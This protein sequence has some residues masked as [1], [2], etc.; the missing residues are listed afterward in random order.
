MGGNLLGERRRREQE[1]QGL[2]RRDAEASH[3]DLEGPA[4]HLGQERRAEEDEREEE[5]E[6]E[7]A[8]QELHERRQ[9]E[10]HVEP[11]APV[12]DVEEVVAEL[13]ARVGEVAAAELGQA[14]H[15]RADDE[16]GGVVRD[17]P[18]R[19]REEHGAHGARPDEVHLAAQDVDE[20]G[21][22]VELG[23]PQE[24]ADRRVERV[25]RAQETAADAL[26]G[27][28]EQRAELVDGEG[29]EVLAD[30]RPPVEHGSGARELDCD[31]DHDDHREEQEEPPCGH[32]HLP[33][34]LPAAVG[35]ETER[36][37][38]PQRIGL[39]AERLADARGSFHRSAHAHARAAGRTPCSTSSCQTESTRS[40][41]IARL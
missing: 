12:A 22:L 26:L 1:A 15:A 34:P 21:D 9:H 16:A 13:V 2:E 3:G 39:H 30:A 14:G 29:L 18:H 36:D 33:P 10:L 37:E 27:V 31:C 6:R 41:Q 38:G 7:P 11:E 4:E 5:P 35:L 19:R 23:A 32:H 20:L 24:A 40:A 28:D 17:L 8:V 25:L